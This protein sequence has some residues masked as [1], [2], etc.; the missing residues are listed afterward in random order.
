MPRR[1]RVRPAPDVEVIAELDRTIHAPARLM[2]LAHLAVMDGTDFNYLLRVTGLTR[3]NL[4]TH[5]T[6]LEAA[7]YV[8][9]TKEFVER[10]PRTLVQLSPEGREAVSRYRDAMRRVV[11]DLLAPRPKPAS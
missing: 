3:G 1:E 10:I 11:D 8:R 7:G 2:I 9:I 6:K 4:S 5:L